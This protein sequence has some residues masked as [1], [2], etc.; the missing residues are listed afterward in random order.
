MLLLKLSIVFFFYCYLLL[1]IPLLFCNP[2]IAD[3]D[4]QQKVWSALDRA[5]DSSNNSLKR[6]TIGNYVNG[7]RC[8]VRQFTKLLKF[9]T[10]SFRDRSLELAK[11]AGIIAILNNILV[12]MVP[13]ACKFV[14]TQVLFSSYVVI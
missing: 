4:L 14:G 6:S 13:T 3:Y 7:V 5:A 1:L 2:S 11:V 10:L 8:F 9:P 12:D